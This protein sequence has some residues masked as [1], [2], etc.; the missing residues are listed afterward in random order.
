MKRQRWSSVR[1]ERELIRASRNMVLV[2]GRLC[3]EVCEGERGKA[4]GLGRRGGGE[5]E[6]IL[7]E[8]SSGDGST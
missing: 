1:A 8:V 4:A 5:D 7:P 6:G 3:R 2:M